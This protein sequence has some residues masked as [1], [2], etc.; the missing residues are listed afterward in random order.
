MENERQEMF[1]SWEGTC[2]RKSWQK[3]VSN[4]QHGGDTLFNTY[5]VSLVDLKNCPIEAVN[6]KL[7]SSNPLFG[8]QNVAHLSPK[9]RKSVDRKTEEKR[10]H[11]SEHW[12]MDK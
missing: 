1:S 11:T 9:S 2:Q 8:S 3:Y 5:V 10:D 7:S 6:Q 4:V 12:Q